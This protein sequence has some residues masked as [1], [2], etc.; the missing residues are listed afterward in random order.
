MRR[1]Y[2][3]NNIMYSVYNSMSGHN[4]N[5]QQVQ[6]KFAEAFP[7]SST[8]DTIRYFFAPGRANLMGDHID[9]CGG[10]VLPAA[11]SAGTYVA[12]RLMPALM[13]PADMNEG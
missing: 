9:Y 8:N 4:S 12:A 1:P 7:Y 5:L 10:K 11:I 2:N 13:E 3:R 6:K